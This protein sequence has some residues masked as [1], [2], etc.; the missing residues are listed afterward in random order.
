MKGCGHLPH[1]ER[2]D[3]SG[4]LYHGFLD[5]VRLSTDAHTG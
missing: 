5:D 3:E 1:T 4:R 2:P